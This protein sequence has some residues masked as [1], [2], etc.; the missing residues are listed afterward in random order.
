MLDR[1]EDTLE[2][3][4]H[5]SQASIKS[6][7]AM[8]M[9]RSST[10]RGT[11]KENFDFIKYILSKPPDQRSTFELKTML[12]PLM[13]DIAFF[14]ERKLK[15]QEMVEICGGLQYETCPKDSFI[16]RYAEEGEKF[17]IILKGKVSVWIP[18]P[19]DQMRQ[20][21]DSLLRKVRNGEDS[22]EFHFLKKACD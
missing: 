5:D 9:A 20:P 13:A 17:Y 4:L 7:S 10:S 6:R 15:L 2:A 16:I 12:T 1:R 22:F 8:K 21:I 3:S 19:I 18:Q 11:M 14:K